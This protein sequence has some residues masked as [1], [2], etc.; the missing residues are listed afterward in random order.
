MRQGDSSP[1]HGQQHAPLPQ[2]LSPAAR[3]FG[4]L[5]ELWDRAFAPAAPHAQLE[6]APQPM[7]AAPELA[8]AAGPLPLPA[9]QP[10][11]LAA[12]WTVHAAGHLAG[13][14]TKEC[15]AELTDRVLAG[16]D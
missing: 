12:S 16:R 4:R 15:A 10:A 6:E 8:P 1:G 13:R 14:V 2:H 5:L 9:V 3:D 7:R 11:E